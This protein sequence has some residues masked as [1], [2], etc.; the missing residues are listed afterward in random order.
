M[1]TNFPTSLDTLTNPTSS[2]SLS[3]PSHSAQ[4]AN[5]ND[6]VEALQAKVGVDGSAVTTSL[7]YKVAQQ[8]LVLV[9]TQTIGTAVSSVTVSDAFSSTFDNYRI[10]VSGI[11]MSVDTAVGMRLGSVTTGYYGALT[12][13]SYTGAGPSAASDNNA[14]L[15]T[16]CGGGHNT[17]SCLI[18]VMMPFATT[19]TEV[20]AR[21][22]YSTVYGVY[23]GHHYDATSHTSF[24]LS[25]AAGTMT[26]G[27]IRVY[28]YN[29]G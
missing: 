8:G 7:D 18:E 29:N 20:L 2:D 4:H 1:A 27:T 12:Y 17:G 28:G 14:A 11:G 13:A 9:K 15:F 21:Q 5:V 26:G 22:R 16:Y 6:A 10:Q 24:T 25:P 23:I 19:N 3:S